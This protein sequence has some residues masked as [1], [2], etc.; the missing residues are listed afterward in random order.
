MLVRPVEASNLALE[1]PSGKLWRPIRQA[2]YVEGLLPWASVRAHDSAA[3][4]MTPGTCRTW[5]GNLD[6]PSWETP[7]PLSWGT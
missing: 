2:L 6:L 4:Y 3:P 7:L 1:G 5:A